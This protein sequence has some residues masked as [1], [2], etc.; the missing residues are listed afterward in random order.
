[1]KTSLLITIGLLVCV[2][3]LTGSTS[4]ASSKPKTEWHDQDLKADIFNH[5]LNLDEPIE[6]VPLSV[7]ELT[8][9]LDKLESEG[10]FSLKFNK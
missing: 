6:T 4:A 8:K 10:K 5:F 7:D 9:L 1:M 2:L 3:I